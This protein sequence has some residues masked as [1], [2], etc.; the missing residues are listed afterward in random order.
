[1]QINHHNHN[2]SGGYP[3]DVGDRY[4][5][6]DMGRDF[7]ALMDQCGAALA[8]IGINTGS[9]LNGGVVTQGSTKAKLNVTNMKGLVNFDVTVPLSFSGLPPTTQTKTVRAVVEMPAQTDFNWTSS[10]G[11]VADNATVN[12]LKVQYAEAD[13]SSRNRFKSGGSYA[14]EKIPSFNLVCNPT[15][16]T[17]YE[18]TIAKIVGDGSVN[19]TITQY[20]GYL[21]LMLNATQT[22]GAFDNSA[23]NPSHTTRINYDGN[24]W[25]TTLQTPSSRRLKKNIKK[26]RQSALDIINSV[27]VVSYKL[28]ADKSGETHVG[29]IAEDTD[30]LL[31]GPGHDGV[32]LTDAVGILLKGIQELSARVDFLEANHGN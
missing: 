27:D 1:M 31:S 3:L 15:A 30:A 6:Q 24:L 20:A 11:A 18:A 8:S 25:A 29:F 19:L 12:Y 32:R 13:G 7:W 17:S 28:R 4:Y 14:Y 16:P 26:F 9:L 10:S 22:A 21:A 2:Y 23:T 5:A